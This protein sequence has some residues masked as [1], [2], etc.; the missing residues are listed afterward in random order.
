MST[1]TSMVG[2]LV[3]AT[4]VER[5]GYDERRPGM[6]LVVCEYQPDE[7][8][9]LDCVFCED[10][11]GNITTIALYDEHTSA[12]MQVC[13]EHLDELVQAAILRHRQAM[14]KEDPYWYLTEDKDPWG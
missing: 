2:V 7:H 3:P 10:Q 13:P 6:R 14:E 5:L 4:Q 12:S 11:T 8:G 1:P 9:S